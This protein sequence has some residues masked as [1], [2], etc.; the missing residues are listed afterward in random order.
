LQVRDK[1][2]VLT[3]LADKALSQNAHPQGVEALLTRLFKEDIHFLRKNLALPYHC[4][5]QCHYFGGRSALEEQLADRV[6]DDHLARDIRTAKAFEVLV[7]AL[8]AENIA[9]WGQKKRQHLLDIL[10]AY[11]GL[12]MLLADLERAHSGNPAVQGWINDLRSMLQRLAPANLVTLYDDDRLSHLKRYIKGIA[13]RA[14]RGA[15]NLEKDRAKARRIEPYVHRL[16]ML[17]RGLAPGNSDAKRQAVEDFFWL[18]EE[19]RIAVFAPEIKTS[20]PV[21]TKKLDNRLK[22]I[23]NLV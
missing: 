15:L 16:E 13:V 21:S 4:Q 14:E 6:L 5:G 1:A 8:R 7:Q 22:E 18:L 12:R 20:C 23:D 3:A 2:I 9:A 17:V 10:D 19:Y 11:H